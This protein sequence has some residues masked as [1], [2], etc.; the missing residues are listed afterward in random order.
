MNIVK[1]NFNKLFPKVGN[2]RSAFSDLI[3]EFFDD[4]F[5]TT[6]LSKSDWFPK[7]DIFEKDNNIYV[8]ADLPG[9]DE[10]NLNIELEGNVLTISGTTEESCEKKDKNYHRIERCYGS[11]TRSFTLPDNIDV[12]KIN[13][14]YKKGVLSITIPKLKKEDTKKIN[15]KIS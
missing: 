13:A 5:F 12:E 3:S 9:I 15:V 2:L 10:K 6:E 7:V 14:E 1:K 11:F 8:K 4:E